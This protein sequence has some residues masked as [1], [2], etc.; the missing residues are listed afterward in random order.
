MLAINHGHQLLFD[1]RG[2]IAQRIQT[3]ALQRAPCSN[4]ALISATSH[5]QCSHNTTSRLVGTL[6]SMPRSSRLHHISDLRRNPSITYQRS[7]LR[8]GLPHTL[9]PPVPIILRFKL[10]MP[11]TAL[12][13]IQPRW[14]CHNLCKATMPLL[15]QLL[16]QYNHQRHHIRCL[17]GHCRI[18]S[19]RILIR[20]RTG[21]SISQHQ[22]IR[23][24]QCILIR[25]R[26]G[27]NIDPR[28]C[29]SP[30][31]SLRYRR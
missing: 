4:S 7:M 30:V 17:V 2:T 16:G 19:Q 22:C 23:R 9:M 18:L 26:T 1:L 13:C 8:L 27:H 21:R 10:I 15:G 11:P 12:M 31:R 6:L 29:M 24:R 25:L 20:L 14:E 3:S 28:L 5:R